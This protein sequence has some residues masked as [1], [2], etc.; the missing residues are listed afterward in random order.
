ML[1]GDSAHFGVNEVTRV[2][3]WPGPAAH[4]ASFSSCVNSFCIIVS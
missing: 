1:G 4:T 3:L 2:Y